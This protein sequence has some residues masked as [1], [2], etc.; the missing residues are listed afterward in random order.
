MAIVGRQDVAQ[1]GLALIVQDVAAA[2]DFY[3]D[4]LGAQEVVRNF[5][6]NPV[7]PPSPEAASAEM[8]LGG[9][10]LMVTRENPRWRQAPRADWPRSPVSAGA[11]SAFMALYV[12]DIDAVFARAKAAG[13]EPTRKDDVPEDGYW[14]DRVVQFHDPFGHVWRIMTRVEDVEP[15]ELA[16]RFAA[17]IEA[18]RAARAAGRAGG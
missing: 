3:R 15:A 1:L 6:P 9:T 17:A 4:V 7:D 18:H 12:D 10:Y 5:A 8:R 13:A 14:G 16:P 2:A 11:A